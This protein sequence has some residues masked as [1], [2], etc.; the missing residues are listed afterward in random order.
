MDDLWNNCGVAIVLAIFLIRGVIAWI[1]WRAPENG[2][3]RQWLK[4]RRD[5]RRAVEKERV[6][7]QYLSPKAFAQLVAD[8]PSIHCSVEH[9]LEMAERQLPKG[10]P[11]VF[12]DVI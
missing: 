12:W 3:Y 10:S 2:F 4:Q 6:R 1:A 7:L 11:Q 5:E 8:L 9:L